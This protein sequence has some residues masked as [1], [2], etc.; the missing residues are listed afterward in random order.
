MSKTQLQLMEGIDEE[1]EF[2]KKLESM[3]ITTPAPKADKKT[4]MFNFDKKME[5]SAGILKFS[6]AEQHR[7]MGVECSGMKKRVTIRRLKPFRFAPM[8]RP[9]S[10]CETRIQHETR[11]MQDKV[12]RELENFHF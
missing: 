11:V 8:S 5:L 9:V 2:L 10:G 3:K 7:P 1:K 6:R 12:A 4:F